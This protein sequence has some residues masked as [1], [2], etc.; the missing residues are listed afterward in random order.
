MG[1]D[2]GGTGELGEGG[3]NRSGRGWGRGGNNCL[4]V[5]CNCGLDGGTR[6]RPEE[7]EVSISLA[8]EG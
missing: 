4:E 7:F 2:G 3:V 1:D 8:C 6:S 5:S